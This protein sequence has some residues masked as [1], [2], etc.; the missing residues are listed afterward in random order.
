MRIRA[1]TSFSDSALRRGE[2][3]GERRDETRNERR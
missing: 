1:A 3:G 2:R